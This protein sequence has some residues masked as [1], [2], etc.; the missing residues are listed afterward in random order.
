MLSVYSIAG[1]HPIFPPLLWKIYP[2]LNL[3]TLTLDYAKTNNNKQTKKHNLIA[4]HNI[5]GAHT[6]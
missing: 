4:K 3:S 6:A 5:L 2:P 1:I